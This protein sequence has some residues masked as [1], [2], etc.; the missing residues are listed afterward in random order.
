MTPFALGDTGLDIT[1]FFFGGAAIGGIGSAPSRIGLGMSIDESLERLDEAY[2]VGLR[3]VDTANS[4]SGGE[5]ERTIGRWREEREY[6]DIVVSTKVGNVV[7]RGQVHISLTGDHIA[8]QLA[9]SRSR[10]GS[11]ELLVTHGADPYTPLEETLTAFASAI[12]TEQ[13]RAFG[14]SNLSVR[15]VEAWLLAADRAGLPRPS[16]IQNNF[17]LLARASER[18]MLPLLAGEDIPFV[19]YSPLAGGVLSSRLLHL[20]LDPDSDEL[21]P[22]APGSRLALAPAMYASTFTLENI[23]RVTRLEQLA[24]EREVSIAGLALS[25]L[26]WHPQITAT[27]VAPRH[28]EQWDAVTEALALDLD[29]DSA[30]QISALFA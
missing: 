27:I 18:D 7:E 20:G 1:E 21:P 26:R 12:E 29:D 3:V 19:A 23:G 8:R 11:V 25:W 30:E 28:T 15:E 2:E 10:L 16:V 4:F 22:R 17:S 9:L 6:E 14:C 24:F 13:I 5:S